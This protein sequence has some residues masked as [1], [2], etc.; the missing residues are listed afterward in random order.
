MNGGPANVW[1]EEVKRLN[2]QF[3]GSLVGPSCSLSSLS[4]FKIFQLFIFM[5]LCQASVLVCTSLIFCAACGMFSRGLWDLS[6][7]TRAPCT[8]WAES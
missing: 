2:V 7:L 3:P 6:S 1:N 8:E 4:L 5:W